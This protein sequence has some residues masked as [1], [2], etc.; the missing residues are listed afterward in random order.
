MEPTLEGITWTPDQMRFL[1]RVIN[2]CST[3]GHPVADER[4]LPFFQR[5]Y[6]WTLLADAV[7]SDLLGERGVELLNE[8]EA[9]L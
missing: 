3:G 1:C 7:E 6:V 8:V 2:R 4:T 5:E 9:K